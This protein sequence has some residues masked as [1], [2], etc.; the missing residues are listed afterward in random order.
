[1]ICRPTGRPS[2]NPQ[3]TVNAGQPIQLN[4]GSTSIETSVNYVSLLLG[5]ILSLVVGAVYW[6]YTWTSMRA[7]P[8]QKML[9]MQVGNSPDGQTLNQE[10]A[11]R[12]WAVLFAPF[13]LSQVV[14]VRLDTD[15]HKVGF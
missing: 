9:G 7:S 14:Y 5:A 13:S 2:T 10:Q 11:I 4:L 3:G 1:M 15:E 6:I 8:G 12:R